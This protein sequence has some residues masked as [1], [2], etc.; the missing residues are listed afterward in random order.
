MFAK[1][2]QNCIKKHKFGVSYTLKSDTM[3][4]SNN[5]IIPAYNR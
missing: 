4:K 5:E 1:H 2:S 3:K